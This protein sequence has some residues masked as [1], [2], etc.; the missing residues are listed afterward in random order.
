M[1]DKSG[2]ALQVAVLEAAQQI[3]IVLKDKQLEVLLSF[4]G[5][6]DIFMSLLTGNG[7][8]MIYG[9]LALIFDKIKG[10]RYS[11]FACLAS[12]FK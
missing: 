1:G 7:K 9:L 5:R 4:C 8:S 12:F 11:Y 10:A 6:N 3:G 2:D